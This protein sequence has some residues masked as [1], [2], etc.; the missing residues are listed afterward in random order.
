MPQVQGTQRLDQPFN[1]AV[2][3]HHS[4]RSRSAERS[5]LRGGCSTCGRITCQRW[6]LSSSSLPEAATSRIS[7]PCIRGSASGSGMVFDLYVRR[8][9][10]LQE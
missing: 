6:Q 7:S 8:V 5:A 3:S 1:V 9:L 4:A 2:P 10:P